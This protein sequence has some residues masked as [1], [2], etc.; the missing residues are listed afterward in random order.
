MKTQEIASEGVPQAPLRLYHAPETS[1]LASQVPLCPV[2]YAPVS[3]S[4]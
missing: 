4:G 3:R 2:L 1:F